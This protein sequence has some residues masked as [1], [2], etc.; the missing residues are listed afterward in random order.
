MRRSRA[1]PWLRWVLLASLRPCRQQRDHSATTARQQ[2][3][4]SMTTAAE[5]I[6]D[7]GVEHR[8]YGRCPLQ[9]R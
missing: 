6:V 3:D 2:R 8:R 1:A 4:S 9:A 7:T 5:R